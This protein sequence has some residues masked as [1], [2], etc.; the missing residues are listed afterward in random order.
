[1]PHPLHQSEESET[2]YGRQPVLEL[3]RAERRPVRRLLM[4]TRAR[5][6]EPI[7]LIRKLAGIQGLRL[8]QVNH[9][10][11]DRLVG[12][13]N[14]Q[15]V[16]A[17]VGPYP[18]VEPEGENFWT[19]FG[20]LLLLDH[21][22]DP[23]NLG[24]I[25][26]TAEAVGVDAVVLP[27]ERSVGVTPAVARVSAGACEHLAVCRVG[28]LRQ[29]MREM[30][31]CGFRLVGLEGMEE[32]EPYSHGK[33]DLPVG[34]VV[35]SEGSGMSRTVRQACDSL[36]RIPMRGKVN[37]L[38]AAAATAVALYEILRQNHERNIHRP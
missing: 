18:Y 10:V 22:Q 1:M 37:S 24:A 3:L 28:S 30:R 38:N 19:S 35:G 9:P 13:A 7:K 8:E 23:Q 20:L 33:L 36:I 17:V 11:L 14:H 15:G 32:A 26:R 25:M 27:Q 16:A 29:A 4:F 34:L 6:S 2:I 21:I 5:P 12:G 31:Q